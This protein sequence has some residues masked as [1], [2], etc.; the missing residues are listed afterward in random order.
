MRRQVFQRPCNDP[1]FEDVALRMGQATVLSLGCSAG[2]ELALSSSSSRR[3]AGMVDWLLGASSTKCRLGGAN[4]QG[5]S[6]GDRVTQDALK[7]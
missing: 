3:K 6:K 4:R 1:G 2:L 5:S 7:V